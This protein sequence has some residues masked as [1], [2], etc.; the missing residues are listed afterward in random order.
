MQTIRVLLVD[1]S[2]DFIDA[3]DRFLAEVGGVE[4][5][6]KEYSGSEALNLADHLRPDLVLMDIS[7][8][9][10]NGLQATT[11]IKTRF[12]P[13]QVIMLTLHDSPQYREAAQQAGA[14]GFV[15]KSEIAELLP[16][17][18]ALSFDRR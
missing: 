10:M 11:R 4:V 6:G 3:I 13:P 2:R 18:G 1:D 9:E 5:I 8:P 17:I 7:M 15:T 12:D 16:A 14:D